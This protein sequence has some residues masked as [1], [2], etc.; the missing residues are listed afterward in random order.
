MNVTE[1]ARPAPAEGGL[2]RV[3]LDFAYDGTRFSGWAM[4]PGLRTVEDELS[5]ALTR[6]VR[7]DRP[8]RLIVAG[9]TDAGVHARGAVAHADVARD[10]WLRLSGRS[11]RTP[12]SAAVRRLNG[13]LPGDIVMRSAREAPEG[14]SARFSARSRRYLYRI[15]DHPASLDPLR[16]ADTLVHR[17]ALDVAAMNAAS[18][19]LVGLQDFVSFCKPRPGA[20]TI[21]TLLDYSWARDDEGVVCASLVADAFCHT[22]VRS[23]IGVVVAVGDG[24]RPVGWPSEVMAAGGRDPAAVVMPAQGLSLMEVTYPPDDQVAA[25]ACLTRARRGAPTGQTF[26]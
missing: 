7:A 3:R 8:V 19:R 6:I 26:R 13:L 14:F 20:T 5:R 2:V 25:Q 23:L 16:R 17:H 21:R 15:C 11:S 24:R 22:M 1:P 12:A 10:G 9:R 4:Q 18:S